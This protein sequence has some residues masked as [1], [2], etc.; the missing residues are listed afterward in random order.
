[1]KLTALISIVLTAGVCTFAQTD[2]HSV[3]FKNFTYSAYCAG[4]DPENLTVKD[5]EY[6]REKENNEGWFRVFW[7][8]YG[9]LNGDGKD[10]AVILSVC[11]T[12]GTGQ[13]SEGFIYSIKAGKPSL[14]ARIPGGDRAYGGLSGASVENGV[15]VV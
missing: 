7:T 15:L 12:G 14:L 6:S 13:F 9:D 5:G 8:K 10:E 1:M 11:N 2:I 4:E 3:D